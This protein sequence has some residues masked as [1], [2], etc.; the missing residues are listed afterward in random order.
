MR[1]PVTSFAALAFAM[2]GACTIGDTNADDSSDGTTDSDSPTPDAS[3]AGGADASATPKVTATVSPPTRM[4]EL[5]TSGAAAAGAQELL[6]EL[7]RFEI[8]VV[9][10]GG[11]TGA[12]DFAVSGLGTGWTATFDPATVTLTDGGSATTTLRIDIASDAEAATKALTITATSTAPTETK[13]ATMTAA[14]VV[15]VSDNIPF[16]AVTIKQGTE[17]R[18]RNDSDPAQDNRMI[19]APGAQTHAADPHDS[20]NTGAFPHESTGGPGHIKGDYYAVKPDQ[21]V[22]GWYGHNFGSAGDQ[23]NLTVLAP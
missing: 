19:H 14:P 22:Y 13:A 7:N 23:V 11:F 4:T 10:E 2:L 20:T 17:F 6:N 12:V 5:R 18:I 3:G 1:T 9:S 21:G 16:P 15:T 8:A